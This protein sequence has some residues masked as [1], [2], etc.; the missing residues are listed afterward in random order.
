MISSVEGIG[1]VE[2]ENAQNEK[3]S[4]GDK[5]TEPLKAY[6]LVSI[7]WTIKHPSKQSHSVNSA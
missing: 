6:F 3:E 1:S 2:C 7:L 4:T 5:N